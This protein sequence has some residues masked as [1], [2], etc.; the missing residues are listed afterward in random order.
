MNDEPTGYDRAATATGHLGPYF[1]WVVENESGSWD[2]RIER[3][4]LTPEPLRDVFGHGGW[5]KVHNG[6]R[7]TELDATTDGA[8]ALRRLAETRF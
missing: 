2:W 1:L 6:F 3:W 8:E 5:S 4:D 7:A